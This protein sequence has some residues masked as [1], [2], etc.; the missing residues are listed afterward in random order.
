MAP[1]GDPVFG[2]RLPDVLRVLHSAC[3]PVPDFDELLE[4]TLEGN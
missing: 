2:N 1:G 4:E 3:S